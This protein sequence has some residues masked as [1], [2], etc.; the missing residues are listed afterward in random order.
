MNK[1]TVT[2]KGREVTVEGRLPREKLIEL[3]SSLEEAS[4]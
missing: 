3:A 2:V 1:V 4:E